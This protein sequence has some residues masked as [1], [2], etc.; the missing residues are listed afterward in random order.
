MK[1]TRQRLKKEFGL[2][3]PEG[4]AAQ[5]TNPLM[6]QSEHLGGRVT[7]Q[8]LRKMTLSTGN[9]LI[10]QLFEMISQE[11]RV[12]GRKYQVLPNL[13]LGAREA[14]SYQLACIDAQFLLC[15]SGF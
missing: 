1:T 12:L 9:F 7:E 14:Q 10:E 6:L 15:W 3:L 13:L 11:F 4:V 2:L 5:W 8:K